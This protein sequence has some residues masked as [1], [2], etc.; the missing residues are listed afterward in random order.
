VFV[1]ATRSATIRTRMDAG[2]V[3]VKVEEVAA[4]E[5]PT[6]SEALFAHGYFL[7]GGV[8]GDEIW[9]DYR[10]NSARNPQTYR[11]RGRIQD[12]KDWRILRLVLTAHDP[13]L[14]GI[15]LMVLVGFSGFYVWMGE[16]VPR[17]ALVILAFVLGVYAVSNLLYIPSVVAQRVSA[18]LASE[19]HG[20]VQSGSKWVVPS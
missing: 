12:A 10:F 4:R 11:V 6:G 5:R 3:R 20:S 13:W 15:E 19:V 14:S 18:L 9:L 8:E 2:E 1:R 17:G 16:M 7:G